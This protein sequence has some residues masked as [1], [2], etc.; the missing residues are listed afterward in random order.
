MVWNR[1]LYKNFCFYFLKREEWTLFEEYCKKKGLTPL[2][3]MR[4]IL[5]EA[6]KGGEKN[7]KN[8]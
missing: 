2:Q 8:D 6:V 5:L 7:G 4:I 3:A 1:G